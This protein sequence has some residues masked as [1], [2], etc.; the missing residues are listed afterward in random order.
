MSTILVTGGCGY[1]GSHT[2]VDLL[3]HNYKVISVDDNSRSSADSLA[4]VEKITG[5]KVKNYKVDLCD[6]DQLRKVFDENKIDGII[7]FA[8]Y[9]AVDESVGDPLLYYRNNFISLFNILECTK[10]YK[11]K[12]FVFSSSCSVY[13]DIDKLPVT[14]DTVLT[15][16]KSPYGRT[17]KVGEEIIK[18]FS[19]TCNSHFSLLRYF[20]PVGAHPS[21][22]IGEVPF[23]RPSNLIPAIT[24]FAAG[25]L[26]QLKVF[27][28][29]YDT[30]DGSC[31]RDF[32]H[33]CDIA[34]AHTL[35]L[36]QLTRLPE[37]SSSY[38]IYNLGTGDG[39]TVLEAIRSFEKVTGIKLNYEIAGV[40]EGDVVSIYADNQK[41]REK[42][43]W[44]AAFSLDDMLKTAW[45]W[46]KTSQSKKAL[47][48]T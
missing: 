23:G 15:E 19:K 37:N 42:L 26:K 41:A 31:I 30:R 45:E 10:D 12:Y 9:K 16:P 40:R 24:Q 1:I 11:V 48:N 21:G 27:G 36:K 18:D 39:V 33:V 47:T 35:A 38:E 3:Q 13:G 32:V 28:D 43:G 22:S 29:K 46:E 25:R 17:K 5:V 20:N 7:H 34:S 8:A 44:K 4:G 14:E 2:L 6:R